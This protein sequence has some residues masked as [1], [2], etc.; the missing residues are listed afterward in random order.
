VQEWES[1]IRSGATWVE[2]VTWN[3]WG[4][5]S[6]VAPFGK[7]ADTELWQGHWGPMLSHEGFLGLTRYCAEWFR[8]G[9]PPAIARDE[10]FYAYR[11]HPKE[12]ESRIKPGEDT[13]GRPGGVDALKDCLFVTALLA[14]PARLTLHSGDTSREFELAAGVQHL[15][16]PF[17]LGPQRLVLSRGDTVLIDKAGEHP[18]TRDGWSNFNVF[19]GSAHAE[20]GG[21][22][23]QAPPGNP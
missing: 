8:T 1:A 22:P 10:L 13:L 11:L 14:A 15:E 5:A 9:K 16:M 20:R 2:I 7:P 12:I 3:D 17:A 6:Y 19:A 4:E 23:A 18:V 21:F